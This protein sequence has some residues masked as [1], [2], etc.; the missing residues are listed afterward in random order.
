[1]GETSRLA[2]LC[3]GGSDQGMC[4]ACG[5]ARHIVDGWVTVKFA[6]IETAGFD[7]GDER[8]YKDVGH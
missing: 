3:G 6:D 7:A 1:M 4:Y 5:I 2:T 8:A